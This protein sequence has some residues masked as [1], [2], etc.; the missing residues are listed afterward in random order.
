MKKLAILCLAGGL[1]AQW[2]DPAR[3]RKIAVTVAAHGP[4][5]SPLLLFFPATGYGIGSYQAFLRSLSGYT[6]VFVQPQY[7]MKAW[8]N[9]G[10]L[11]A[12]AQMEFER[13]EMR[14]WVKD[15][16]FVLGRMKASA[17]GVFGHG[18][19]GIAA[20]AACQ[21]SPAFRACL[22]LDGESMGSP[23]VLDDSFD[24][25]FLLLR[26]LRD[27]PLPPTAAELK[28]RKMTREEF[29]AILAKSG[30]AAMWKSRAVATM[31]TLHAKDA[32]YES[33]TSRRAGTRAF[34]LAIAVIQEFFDEHLKGHRSPLFSGYATGYPEVVYQQFRTSGNR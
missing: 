29:D 21:M 15:G 22:D 3:H 2:S 25:P 16:V 24:Q 28:E 27:A 5:G 10:K 20:A 8:K 19:G 1:Q 34:A 26:P 9:A 4:Q 30:T 13:Q 7:S 17:A 14:E 32:D 18:A 31:V 33:F 6:V 12:A 11:T 23:F